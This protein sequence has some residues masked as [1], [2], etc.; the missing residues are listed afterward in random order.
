MFEIPE[1][2]CL[3]KQMKNKLVGKQIHDVSLTRSEKLE[4]WG[5]VTQTQVEFQDWLKGCRI[6][7]I[8]RTPYIV[9]IKMDKGPLLALGELDGTLIFHEDTSTLPKKYILK[10]DFSDNIFLTVSV[11][12]WRLIKVITPELAR[13]D[14]WQHEKGGVEP[15]SPDFT[16]DYFTAFINRDETT[17]RL[18]V[19]KFIT[20]RIC[21]TGL[22]NGH[23]QEILFRAGLHPKRKLKSLADTEKMRFFQTIGEVTR[24]S[25]KNGGRTTEKDF[26]GKPGHFYSRLNKE[27]VGT[28]CPTCGAAVDKI[29]FEGGA[30][31]LCPSCQPKE[32]V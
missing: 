15:L 23:L 4:R 1:I 28:P 6:T 13:D 16:L 27:T 9:L 8:D 5:F 3:Q 12:L 29:Q 31:Y 25:I 18:N 26:F 32:M 22:G 21:V 20:S 7:G 30:C 24:E 14:S 17:Q 2:I 11:R 19:K 10:V